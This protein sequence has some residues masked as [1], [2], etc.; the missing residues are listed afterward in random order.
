M[1]DTGVVGKTKADVIEKLGQPDVKK[2]FNGKEIWVYRK[3][4]MA[5][6]KPET[7]SIYLTL[8]DGKVTE[9]VGN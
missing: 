4:K 8:E 5:A 1:K 7:I 3:V 9:S 2:V 6:D